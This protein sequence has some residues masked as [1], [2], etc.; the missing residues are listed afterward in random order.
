MLQYVLDTDH[1][2]LF[3]HGHAA[4]V[5][6]VTAEP[7]GT[8]GVTAVTVEEALR[9]RLAHLARA[10][11]VAERIRRYQQMLETVQMLQCFPVASFGQAAEDRFQQLVPLRLRIGTQDL[12]IAAV[13]LSRGLTL[14][15]RNRSD[16]AR[17]PGLNLDDW[18]I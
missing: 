10:R 4:L 6:R 3:E 2:T 5:A 13:V 18:T 11:D 7:V 1:L 14:L 8:V 12:K 17:V 16:F 15:T 9:G